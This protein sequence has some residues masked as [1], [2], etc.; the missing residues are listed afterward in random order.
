MHPGT[1][2][3]TQIVHLLRGGDMEFGEITERCPW[4]IMALDC[5]QDLDAPQEGEDVRVFDN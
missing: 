4:D 2:W 5:G 1:T 3:A